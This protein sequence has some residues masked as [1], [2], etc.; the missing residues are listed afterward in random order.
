M[1]KLLM[2]AAALLLV[3][4]AAACGSKEPE[5]E[6]DDSKYTDGTF[7]GTSTV[8]GFHS[9]SISVTVTVAEGKITAVEVGENEETEGIGGAAMDTLGGKVVEAQGTEGVDKVAGATYSSEA[10]LEAVN[11]ALTKA[12]K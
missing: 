6:A 8:K 10:Y 12:A 4:S 2:I 1:K 11:D 9:D 3:I 7:E 5:K